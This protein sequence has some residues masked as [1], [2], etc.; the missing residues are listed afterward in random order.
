M[1]RRVFGMAVTGIIA[2]GI[3]VA[4]EARE[5]RATSETAPAGTLAPEFPSGARWVQGGP[6]RIADLRGRVVVLHF[7]TNGCVNC[8]HNYPIYRGWQKRYAGQPLTI[9][10]VHTPEFA[11]EAGADA[12]R[13]KAR[14]S[15]LEFP[16]VLDT[17][18]RIWTAWKNRYWPCI[19]LVDK[20][21]R[22]RY[23]WEGELSTD[24]P[25]GRRFAAHVDELLAEKAP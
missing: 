21:G 24:Q 5:G 18:S 8:A 1:R 20:A 23:R 13:A 14:A 22:V 6:L 15:S 9:V 19:Y 25:D 3:L 10:G 12:V 7:W 16:I 4:R 2:A 11:R 17:D